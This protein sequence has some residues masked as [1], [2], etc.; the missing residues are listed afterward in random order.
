MN[1]SSAQMFKIHNGRHNLVRIKATQELQINNA[2]VNQKL[3]ESKG[4]LIQMRL[5]HVWHSFTFWFNS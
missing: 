4:N 5:W 2:N 1:L 3:E